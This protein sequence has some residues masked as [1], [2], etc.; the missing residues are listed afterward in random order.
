MQSPS[1]CQ[2]KPENATTRAVAAPVVVRSWTGAQTRL[3]AAVNHGPWLHIALFLVDLPKRAP[4]RD[5]LAGHE[6]GACGGLSV[7]P[8]GNHGET[9][10]ESAK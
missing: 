6:S 8:D 3:H 4:D 7:Y 9:P 1:I 5:Q 2:S 10:P